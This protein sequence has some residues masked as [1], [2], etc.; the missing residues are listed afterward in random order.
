[1]VENQIASLAQE[2]RVEILRRDGITFAFGNRVAMGRNAPS[3]FGADNGNRTLPG[4][5]TA[6]YQVALLDAEESRI[7]KVF[8]FGGRLVE[9][10]ATTIE[11][12][13]RRVGHFRLSDDGRR[14]KRDDPVKPKVLRFRR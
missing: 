2:E 7:P 10:A 12:A 13:N 8:P 6:E 4:E 3:I 1:M 11:H 14:Q 5:L 9:N